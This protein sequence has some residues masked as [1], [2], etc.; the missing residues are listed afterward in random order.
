[1]KQDGEV[2]NSLMQEL[3]MVRE[4]CN[5]RMLVQSRGSQH[6]KILKPCCAKYSKSLAS[7]WLSYSYPK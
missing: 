4:K 2:E 5:V 3:L 6:F 1:M 7:F